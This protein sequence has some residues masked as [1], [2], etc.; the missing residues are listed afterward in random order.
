MGQRGPKP[1][2]KALRLLRNAPP[3]TRHPATVLA[4]DPPTMPAGLSAA[5][6][7]CWHGL[8]AEMSSVPGLLA[9]ADRG[10]LELAARLEPALRAAASTLRDEGATL[11]VRDKEGQ[12][13]FVQTRPEASFVLKTG[14]L[15]RTLYAEL[16]L[17][18]SGR[19]RVSLSAAPP[20]SKLDQF[21]A[22][23]HGA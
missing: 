23:R 5:E 7:T 20:A 11:T 1:L 22:G 15:L 12:V 9:R 18:P 21:L 2:P 10:V 3:T 14:A 4:A 6:E 16:G 13:R 8:L 19:C 17:S